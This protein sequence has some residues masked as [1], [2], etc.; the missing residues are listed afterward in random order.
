MNFF[1]ADDRAADLMV[2]VLDVVGDGR[3]LMTM[4]AGCPDGAMTASLV[5]EN[6][7]DETEAAWE[8]LQRAAHVMRRAVEGGV[9][10]IV[11]R[12]L[13]GRGTSRVFGWVL[14]EGVAESVSSAQMF[15]AYCTPGGE[16]VAPEPG[17][18]YVEAPPLIL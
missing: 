7:A 5:F 16:L 8:S 14:D 9:G 4:V 6:R 1:N 11:V 18:E 3:H 12:T 15:N 2:A 10:G 13:T 17:V